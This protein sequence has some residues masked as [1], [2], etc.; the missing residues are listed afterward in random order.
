MAASREDGE[1][2]VIKSRDGKTITV[3]CRT[4]TEPSS[5]CRS[6][7]GRAGTI[8]CLP[9]SGVHSRL[10]SDSPCN[11]TDWQLRVCDPRPKAAPEPLLRRRILA[12]GH[13]LDTAKTICSLGRC[14]GLFK[15]LCEDA[16]TAA[17]D[18]AGITYEILATSQ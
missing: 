4:N 18:A 6:R 1:M 8:C 3:S 12:Q 16:E 2:L 5:N 14:F 10:W 7:K 13:S 11:S 17:V 9:C 15:I